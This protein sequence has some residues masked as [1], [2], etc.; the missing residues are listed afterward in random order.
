MGCVR[1]ARLC[2]DL[3]FKFLVEAQSR[4]LL[5]GPIVKVYTRSPLVEV[6]IRFSVHRCF[7]MKKIPSV[8]L[9]RYLRD[10]CEGMM[11]STGTHVVGLAH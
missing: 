9:H 1:S 11:N 7:G 10:F 3:G 6:A 4:A 2:A 8:T 5:H